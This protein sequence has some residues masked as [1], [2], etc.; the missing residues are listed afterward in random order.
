MADHADAQEILKEM[1]LL[2][3]KPTFYIG[4]VDE[5]SLRQGRTRTRTSRPS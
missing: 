1:H 2:T 3:A 4:N 5:A